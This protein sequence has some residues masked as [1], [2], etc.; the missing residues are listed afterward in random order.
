MK[1]RAREKGLADDRTPSFYTHFC[2]PL[3]FIDYLKKLEK[4][5]QKGGH[6]ETHNQEK[7]ESEL[8]RASKEGFAFV[9]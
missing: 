1:N 9:T 2:A 6:Y 5:R 3:L 8:H 7:A 4:S